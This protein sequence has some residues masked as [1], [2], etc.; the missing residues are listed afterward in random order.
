M[1]VETSNELGRIL[2]YYFQD[3]ALLERALTHRSTGVSNNETLEFLG[4]AVLELIITDYLYRKFPDIE[5]G[6]LS[7]RR[8]EIVNNRVALCGVAEQIKFDDY[9]IFN[10][11]FPRVNERAWKKLLADTLEALIGA[12]YIDGGIEEA[13]KFVLHHFKYFLENRDRV[14]RKN[15]KAKLQEYLHAQAKKSPVYT[16]ISVSGEDHIPFFTVSCMVNGLAEPV[17]GKGFKVKDAEQAAA[18]K[19]YELLSRRSNK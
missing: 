1:D 2:N 11:S 3:T 16:T 14:V 8:S 19:A 17:T 9:V 18:Q 15:Y 12:I 4:D 10:K 6:F 7:V 13:R 5:E